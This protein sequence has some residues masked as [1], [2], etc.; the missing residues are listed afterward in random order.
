MLEFEQR[1]LIAA[2][3]PPNKKLLEVIMTITENGG[4]I[5]AIVEDAIWDA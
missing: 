1:N 3:F 4:P 5:S 2:G